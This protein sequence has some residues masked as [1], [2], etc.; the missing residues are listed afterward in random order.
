MEPLDSQ[1]YKTEASRAATATGDLALNFK[2]LGET[3]TEIKPEEDTAR[4]RR[5]KFSIQDENATP[6][7]I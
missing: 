2:G 6:K 5:H 7:Q 1:K 3:A 4:T